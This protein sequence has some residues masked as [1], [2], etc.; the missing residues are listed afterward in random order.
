MGSCSGTGV[1]CGGRGEE[2]GE[3]GTVTGPWSLVV[4]RNIS[5]RSKPR[6]PRLERPASFAD[7]ALGIKFTGCEPQPTSFGIK[8]TRRPNSILG[9]IAPRGWAEGPGGEGDAGHHGE[10]YQCADVYESRC[11]VGSDRT[12]EIEDC[13]GIGPFLQSRK[14]RN[15]QGNGAEELP[16]PQD[17][18]EVLRVAEPIHSHAHVRNPEHVPDTSQDELEF[19]QSGGYPIGNSPTCFGA[20]G[21]DRAPKFIAGTMPG[22]PFFIGC[23]VGLE[24]SV[25][26]RNLE[27][28]LLTFRADAL[29]PRRCA[30]EERSVTR[31]ADVAPPATKRI[32][33]LEDPIDPIR[34]ARYH[35]KQAQQSRIVMGATMRHEDGDYE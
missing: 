14:P 33:V 4:G 1:T 30:A 34:F 13:P 19:E 11:Q 20:H 3:W 15:D 6:S 21:E 17:R 18:E 29:Q 23:K 9:K 5:P 32:V 35:P 22:H 28:A 24:P 8:G 16:D 25:G 12:G 10:V 7:F 31:M 27:E 2:E 26:L